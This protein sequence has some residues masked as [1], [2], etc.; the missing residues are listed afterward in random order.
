MTC[1]W[2]S[3]TIKN[4]KMVNSGGFN[5]FNTDVYCSEKCKN[6]HNKS[7]SNPKKDNGSKSWFS[8]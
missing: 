1:K 7:K 2:C 5:I 8:W 3:K 6:A 4:G